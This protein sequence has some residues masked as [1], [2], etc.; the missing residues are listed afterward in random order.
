[1]IIIVYEKPMDVQK[2]VEYWSNGSEE[3][4]DVARSL[5]NSGKPRHGMFFAHLALEKM[6]KAHVTLRTKSVP[7][8]THNLE[9]LA[10]LGGIELDPE[11]LRFL[12]EFDIYQLEGRYPEA[13]QFRL[14]S[15][16]VKRDFQTAAETVEWLKSQ[17]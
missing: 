3:D 7:P 11:R 17:L 16:L 8:K 1:M 6:L 13:M 4:L 10:R 5:V 2:H 14:D 9:K 12:K 15:E